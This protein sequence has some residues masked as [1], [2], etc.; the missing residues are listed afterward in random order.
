MDEYFCDWG[1]A[2]NGHWDGRGFGNGYYEGF[3]NG[4]GLSKGGKNGIGIG[5]GYHQATSALLD[6]NIRELNNG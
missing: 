1:Y 3:S 4:G 5:V 2:Y 6:E